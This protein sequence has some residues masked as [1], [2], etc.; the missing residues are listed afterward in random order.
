MVLEVLD[1]PTTSCH[2]EQ[3]RGVVLLV[4]SELAAGIPKGVV[5]ALLVNLEEDGPNATWG[6]VGICAGIRR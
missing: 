3:E 5:V 1:A 4:V 2:L 6:L